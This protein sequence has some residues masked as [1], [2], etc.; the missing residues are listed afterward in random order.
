MVNFGTAHSRNSCA[1]S[2]LPDDLPNS[3]TKIQE[4]RY[5]GLPPIARDLHALPET[6]HAWQ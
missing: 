4:G 1:R 5:A 6:G 2:K 3:P